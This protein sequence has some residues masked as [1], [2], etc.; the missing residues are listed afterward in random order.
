[1]KLRESYT[2]MMVPLCI[3]EA[4]WRVPEVGLWQP[5]EL[6]L[7]TQVFYDYIEQWLLAKANATN[8]QSLPQEIQSYDLYT[9]RPSHKVTA[10]DSPEQQELLGRLSA[11]RRF[12]GAKWRQQRSGVAFR[13]QNKEQE[14][15][16]VKLLVN[17][18]SRNGLL[19]IPIRLD[20]RYTE[21]T[22]L[23]TLNYYQDKIDSQAML[24][25][26][27]ADLQS[28]DPRA[29]EKYRYMAS[30]MS[31]RYDEVTGPQWTMND[32]ISFLL[33]DFGDGCRLFNRTRLHLF[34]YLR[35]PR[36]QWYA[37]DDA[38]RR[39][40]KADF[41]SLIR[42]QNTTYNPPQQ[43]LD[44]DR[45]FFQTFDNVYVG[46]S[47]EG[48]AILVLSNPEDDKK[49]PT[50]FF[51]NFAMANLLKRY[52]WIYLIVVLQRHALL[53]MIGELSNINCQHS[54]ER[55][56]NQLRTILE[57]LVMVKTCTYY[58]N[59]SDYTQHNEFY[60]YCSHQ[61]HI[62]EQY[63]EIS[64]KMRLLETVINAKKAEADDVRGHRLEIILAVLTIISGICDLLSILDLGG[65]KTAGGITTILLL[66]LLIVVVWNRKR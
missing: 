3:D 38:V 57:R 19:L 66:I 34:T 53:Q 29:V 56:I 58:T 32:L 4:Q 22:D 46:A 14:L 43:R 11:L 1:M 45:M 24:C 50:T 10:D 54:N 16:S 13:F 25:V 7:E 47:V 48:G 9:L 59:I 6:K 36:E 28:V 41:V 15:M 33:S 62:E 20:D 8:R 44:S 65:M 42:S 12:I 2:W 31:L 49:G 35:V 40:N 39:Q 23:I 61:M 51:N 60:K 55:S 27:D 26:L 64:E 63:D 52:L 37:D 18:L 17:R 21:V 30:S 5:A